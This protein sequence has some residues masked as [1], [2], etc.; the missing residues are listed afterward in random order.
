MLHVISF[1]YRHEIL[2]YNTPNRLNGSMFSP[3]YQAHKA[4]T[5]YL[6]NIF[7]TTPMCIDNTKN[8]YVYITVL[9]NI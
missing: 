8:N 7:L 2:D 6:V 4:E 5:F 9:M 1:V 3:K